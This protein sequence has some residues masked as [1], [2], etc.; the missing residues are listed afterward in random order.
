M[1]I[2]A[3]LRSCV[4]MIDSST[5]TT[6]L[7]KF[8]E[9]ISILLKSAFLK[10]SVSLSLDLPAYVKV[11]QFSYVLKGIALCLVIKV[12]LNWLISLGH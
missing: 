3:S 11:T 7:V 4:Q 6:P 2:I 1:D 10:A 9:I 5:K 12:F 8:V